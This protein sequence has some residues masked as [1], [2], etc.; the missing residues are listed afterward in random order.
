MYE[1]FQGGTTVASATSAIGFAGDNSWSMFGTTATSVAR[2]GVTTNRLG[3]YSIIIPSNDRAALVLGGAATPSA[4]SGLL[5]SELVRF[6]W[7]GAPNVS[8]GLNGKFR[9]GLGASATAADFGTD[10]LF[11]EANDETANVWRCIARKSGVATIVASTIAW[12][13]NVYKTLRLE[14]L[15]TGNVEFYVDNVLAG[16]IAASVLPTARLLPGAQI[17]TTINSGGTMNIDTFD[18]EYTRA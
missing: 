6:T 2:S 11:F 16:T 5:V 12:S 7:V 13:N 14:R 9:W 8:A 18:L 1:T 15:S 17:Q 3:T 10:G 4:G